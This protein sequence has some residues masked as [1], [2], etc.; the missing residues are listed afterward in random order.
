M[1]DQ[2]KPSNSSA[3]LVAVATPAPGS[4]NDLTAL[5]REIATLPAKKRLDRLLSRK[6]TMRVIRRMP[7]LDLYAT[8]N[9]V[10]IEDC[11]EVL[12]LMS[13]AQVQGFLDLD[14]WRKDRVDPVAMARWVRVFRTF[15]PSL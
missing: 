5:Y 11:L 15:R 14:A 6:D 10:G 4:V 7:V 9:D 12:E 8:V 1:S 13:P 3:A 2:P